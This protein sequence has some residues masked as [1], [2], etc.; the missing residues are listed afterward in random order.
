VCSTER[1]AE[2]E[3]KPIAGSR[4][5]WWEVVTTYRA[6]SGAPLLKDLALCTFFSHTVQYKFSEPIFATSTHNFYVH[7]K[8]KG[9]ITIVHN[10]RL[11]TLYIRYHTPHTCNSSLTPLPLSLNS[12]VSSLDP[13]SLF[14]SQSA[15]P[16]EM[17]SISALE[18]S[19]KTHWPIRDQTLRPRTPITHVHMAI[20]II[21][22]AH[23]KTFCR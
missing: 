17:I 1:L 23:L 12:S 19:Q 6:S 15:E 7:T 13:P 21:S 5:S 14:H 8:G 20:I 10:V 11:C 18:A 16:P 2:W 3:Q 22:S 9:L 4:C